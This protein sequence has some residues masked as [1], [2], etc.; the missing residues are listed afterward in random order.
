MKIALC[1]SGQAR[2]FRQGHEYFNRNLFAHYD[3]DVYIH[4]WQ[5]DDV[6]QLI[7]LYHPVAHKID[8]PLNVDCSKYTNVEGIKTHLHPQIA[9]Y[10]MYYSLN[11]C[12][13]L[14]QSSTV[15]Y[16]WVIKSRTDWAFNFVP[17]FANLDNKKIYIPDD[18]MPEERD[19]GNDQFAFGPVPAMLKYMST[20]EN[21]DRYHDSGALF[22]GEHLM[23]ANLR[24]HNLH[25][26]NLEFINVNHPFPPNQ[27]GGRQ[28][29]LIRDD[30]TQWRQ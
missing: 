3:V 20:F 19:I 10:S 11:E 18:I 17:D 2:S 15:E 27:W 1:L 30:I 14:L 23:R 6:Q 7:D 28:N 5:F 9:T 21:I 24:E 29:S 16:Q 12:R 26:S 25:G 22:I 13:K 8:A 4:T